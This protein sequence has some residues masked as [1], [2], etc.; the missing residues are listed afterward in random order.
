MTFDD[1]PAPKASLRRFCVFKLI[2]MLAGQL[3]SL[4]KT[5]N[6]LSFA[7]DQSEQDEIRQ[8]P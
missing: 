1:Q 7:G 3:E 8:L 6:E 4:T 2:Q 5:H